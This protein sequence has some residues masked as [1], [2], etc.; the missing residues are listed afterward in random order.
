MSSR[1]KNIRNSSVRNH[2]EPVNEETSSRNRL[3]QSE[4]LDHRDRPCLAA[5]GSVPRP[6]VSW[7][8]KPHQRA[9]KSHDV[10]EAPKSNQPYQ[11]PGAEGVGRYTNLCPDRQ[12]PC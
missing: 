1:Q 6:P 10:L 11:V 12:M 5:L 4:A 3:A 8:F 7:E 9:D 2:E